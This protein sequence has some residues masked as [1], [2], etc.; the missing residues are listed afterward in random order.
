MYEAGSIITLAAGAYQLRAPLAQSA[1]GVLWRADGPA[2][3]GAVAL[4]LVNR[5]QMECAS[6][7]QRPC[8]IDNANA[9]IAF[10]SSLQT[11]DQRHIVRL[12]DSGLH[13]GLPAFALEL[14][15]GDLA[16]YMA[17]L[18]RRCGKL[19]FV[20][21]LSWLGQV[22]Q[23]LAKVHQYGWRYLDLKPANLLLECD[24][25]LKLTDFGASLPLAGPQAHPYTG[26]ARWQAPEQFFPQPGG[27]YRTDARTD[28]FALGALFFYLVSGGETL[29]FSQL[30]A[31]AFRDHGVEAA[32]LLRVR[33]DGA[34]PPLLA[35]EARLFIHHVEDSA[36]GAGHEALAL[37]RRLLDPRPEQRPRHALD[38]SRALARIGATWRI[39]VRSA[40]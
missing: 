1:Y 28:Y 36:P 8:W 35:S 21:A 12:L 11:W 26:T 6:A 14:L 7:A 30:C 32:K 4:K 38:I 3:I 23:A 20:R 33:H 29:R 9:E 18:R 40:A 19:P 2:A 17:E 24:G 5:A 22:N 34:P 25:S 27:T 39:P 31:Q 16:K 13:Q 10:L 37:L 15:D